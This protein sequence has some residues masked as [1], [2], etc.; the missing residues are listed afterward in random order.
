M[1]AGLGEVTIGHCISLR[2]TGLGDDFRN[3]PTT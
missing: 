3:W 2:L 1:A